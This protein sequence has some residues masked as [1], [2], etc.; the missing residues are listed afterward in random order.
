MEANRKW[1]SEYFPN[2]NTL[3]EKRE[4]AT[5]TD[6]LRNTQEKILQ[7]PLGQFLENILRTWQLK[8]AR[9]KTKKLEIH[10]P[11]V[12]IN[13]NILKFHDKDAR[14]KIQDQFLSRFRNSI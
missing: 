9:N 1:L 13:K 7:S 14:K 2:F 5:N 8:R 10:P 4:L 11:A 12:I 3:S 6:N